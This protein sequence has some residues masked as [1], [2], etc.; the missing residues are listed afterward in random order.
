MNNFRLLSYLKVGFHVCDRCP[1]VIR[2]CEVIKDL[3]T[4]GNSFRTLSFTYR[5]GSSEAE[6]NIMEF[7]CRKDLMASIASID[8]QQELERHFIPNRE[9]SARTLTCFWQ[10]VD[11]VAIEKSWT[12]KPFDKPDP[13]S[14]STD[15]PRY[16][17]LP[18]EAST[19]QGP[20]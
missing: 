6:E 13:F 9:L 18:K 15:G 5:F 20:A 17:I 8:V 3:A 19:S 2:A 4:L 10:F 16:L 1:S 12:V 14:L 7:F 11:E